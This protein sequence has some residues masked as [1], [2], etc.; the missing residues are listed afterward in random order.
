MRLFRYVLC[1]IAAVCPLARAQQGFLAVTQSNLVNAAGAPANAQVCAQAVDLLGKPVS[2]QVG[3]FAGGVTT[4]SK[5]CTSAV[6]G[7]WSLNL[8]N[9]TLAQP[10]NSCFNVTAVDSVTNRDLIGPGYNC[11]QPTTDP[12]SKWCSSSGCNFDKLPPMSR[13]TLAS[14]V[15]G[16][17]GTV[18]IGLTV[19][20]APGTAALVANVGTG[21]A[22]KLQFTVPQGP[23]GV[24]GF[25]GPQGNP[26]VQGSVGAA[27]PTGPPISVG[28]TDGSAVVV[29]SGGTLIC[30]GASI[31]SAYGNGGTNPYCA[32]AMQHPYLA[33]RYTRVQLAV[34]GSSMAD[35]VS[36]YTASVKP[37]CQAATALHP[38]YYVVDSDAPYN[39]ISGGQSASTVFAAYES[40]LQQA[41][42]D[43]CRV[44]AGTIREIG[45]PSIQVATETPKFNA[46]VRNAPA[47][48]YWTLADWH[49]F[50]PF[51]ADNCP[52]VNG[53]VSCSANSIH[54]GFVHFKT[55]G[56]KLMGDYL[57][58]L[59]TGQN[60][61]PVGS[62]G[63]V[64]AQPQ[65][66]SGQAYQN[67][68][69][70]FYADL[71]NDI[72]ECA[73]NP[74]GIALQFAQRDGHML[75]V[76]N[77]GAGNCAVSTTAQGTTIDGKDGAVY[78][79]VLAPGDTIRLL[80][81]AASNNWVVLQKP[82]PDPVNV[83]KVR[84]LSAGGNHLV[85]GADD[86]VDCN[87]NEYDAFQLQAGQLL[88]I[89]T[90]V[91]VENNSTPSCLVL[92]SAGG[93]VTLQQYQRVT[94]DYSAG[95]NSLVRYADQ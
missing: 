74:N 8:P 17:A 11:V 14:I 93:S 20:G 85:F 80:Y 7:A 86:I 9:T 64:S 26:G 75:T 4:T 52:V 73:D 1:A 5:V 23:Q 50:V 28:A 30:D 36:R 48:S 87:G 81:E 25:T 95:T 83:H 76:R 90:R 44:V 66:V 31:A 21:S 49:T 34:S 47:G 51:D 2:L 6:S 70:A 27:G 84:T 94:L 38:A 61:T 59:L 69:A 91:I 40:L 15:Q 77:A 19:T 43:G 12:S 33:G 29:P 13:P 22:A 41:T 46:L 72:F 88:K 58:S 54:A 62:S 63:R 55:A 39:S 71:Q 10:I 57:V 56:D 60:A 45:L 79:P 35:L 92:P 53:A 3:G 42:S 89:G 68:A 82:I 16:P 67:G 18:A 24:R 32:Y 78:P 65:L 37:R